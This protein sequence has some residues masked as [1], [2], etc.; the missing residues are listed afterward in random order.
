MSMF[1]PSWFSRAFN[2]K[3]DKLGVEPVMSRDCSTIKFVCPK[4][5]DKK[6]QDEILNGIPEDFRSLIR[7][8]WKED[9]KSSTQGAIEI[10]CSQLKMVKIIK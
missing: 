9:L 1:N 2:E 3:C 6:I 5:P 7:A 4:I 10:I 8:E